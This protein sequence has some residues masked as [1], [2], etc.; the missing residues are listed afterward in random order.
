MRIVGKS[1]IGRLSAKKGKVYAQIRLPPQLADTIGDVADIFETEHNG[2]RAFL[3][4]TRRSVPKDNTVL[5]LD[6]KV[7]K[8]EDYEDYDYRLCALESE[9]NHLKSFLLL[10]KALLFSIFKNSMGSAGF[11]PATSA[12]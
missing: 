7:V 4:V 3:L 1:K 12:V 10:T 2:K 5:Q 6:E 11:E 9:I 8:S